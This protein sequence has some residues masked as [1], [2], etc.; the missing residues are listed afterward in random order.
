MRGSLYEEALEAGLIYEGLS[1]IELMDYTHYYLEG[2]SSERP[3]HLELY[4]VYGDCLL[5]TSKRATLHA[6]LPGHMH[7]P[8]LGGIRTLS[9][10]FRPHHAVAD[11]RNRQLAG[12]RADGGAGNAGRHLKALII[13]IFVNPGHDFTPDIQMIPGLAR[14]AAQTVVIVITS[15]DARRIICLL[16][17]SFVFIVSPSPAV[18]P[19]PLRRKR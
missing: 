3:A 15:P 17:T 7:G 13:Q 18:S 1:W 16:Y 6:G 19:A 4:S 5:Y 14:A 12:R 2:M 10:I 11:T 8:V 9:K